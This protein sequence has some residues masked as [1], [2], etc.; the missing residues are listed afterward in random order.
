MS[1]AVIP[2]HDIDFRRLAM[3]RAQNRID[4][5]KHMTLKGYSISPSLDLIQLKYGVFIKIGEIIY[6]LNN[7]VPSSTTFEKVMTLTGECH[8][9]E[10]YLYCEGAERVPGNFVYDGRKY[11]GLPNYTPTLST[12]NDMFFYLNILELFIRPLRIFA[13][14]KIRG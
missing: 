8:S 10:T 7:Y 1:R 4:P 14:E 9:D 2:E 13:A 5:N 3:V 12:Y 11:Y 6:S